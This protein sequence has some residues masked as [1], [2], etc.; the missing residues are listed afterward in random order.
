MSFCNHFISITYEVF[1]Q[2][3]AIK[4]LCEI[5]VD[6]IKKM[7]VEIDSHELKLALMEALTNALFYGSLEIPSELRGSKGEETFWQMVSQ[8]ERDKTYLSRKIILR[9]ECLKD[10]LRCMVT[11]PGEGFDWRGHKNSMNLENIES[12]HKRG[13]LIIKNCVDELDWNEKGNE[14][15]FTMKFAPKDVDWKR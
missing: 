6:T 7:G 10:G 4:G 1:S 3:E 12:Y 15:T 13:L 8:R 2:R 11:D 14:L 5:A 9:M